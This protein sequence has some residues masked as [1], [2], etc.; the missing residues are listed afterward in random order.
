METMGQ[1]STLRKGST[2]KVGRDADTLFS[3]DPMHRFCNWV[4]PCGLVCIQS[5]ETRLDGLEDLFLWV[6]LR[7]R[8]RIWIKRTRVEMSSIQDN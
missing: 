2:N 6:Q 3:P 4:Y 8:N 1:T 7:Q 5:G